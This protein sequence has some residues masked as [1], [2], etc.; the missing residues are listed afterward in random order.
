MVAPAPARGSRF[1]YGSGSSHSFLRRGSSGSHANGLPDEF[2]QQITEAEASQHRQ[3][4]SN[5]AG[6]CLIVRII[7]AWAVPIDEKVHPREL[8]S[9]LD[10]LTSGYSIVSWT[11]SAAAAAVKAFVVLPVN[12][13]VSGVALT[14]GSIAACE[15]QLH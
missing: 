15:P 1:V 2:L 4:L 3:R 11:T 8:Y 10:Q 9:G 5:S 12:H 7:R 14:S 6:R 13:S